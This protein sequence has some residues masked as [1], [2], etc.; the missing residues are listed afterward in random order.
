MSFPKKEE[1]ESSLIGGIMRIIAYRAMEQFKEKGKAAIF[2][3]EFDESLR[4]EELREK[5][6]KIILETN[7]NYAV[8]WKEYRADASDDDISKDGWYLH[9]S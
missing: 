4:D 3:K 5:I 2:L 9:I 7:P 8:E 6:K 1:V